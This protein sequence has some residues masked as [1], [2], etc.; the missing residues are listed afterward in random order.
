MI[1]GFAKYRRSGKTNLGQTSVPHITELSRG[2]FDNLY[3]FECY[4]H[5]HVKHDDESAVVRDG[6]LVPCDQG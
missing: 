5:H 3:G 6:T 4:V 2:G 1:L